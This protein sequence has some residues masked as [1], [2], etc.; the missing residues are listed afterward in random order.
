MPGVLMDD[1]LLLAWEL[2]QVLGTLVGVVNAV[3]KLIIL[4]VNSSNWTLM[5]L[6]E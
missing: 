6:V 2:G 4:S 3:Q 5:F 1:V